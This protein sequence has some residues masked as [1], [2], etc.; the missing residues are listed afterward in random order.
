MKNY[1][2]DCAIRKGLINPIDSTTISLTGTSYQ[3]EKFVKHT[4]PLQYGGVVSV[5]FWQDYPL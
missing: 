3:L 4:A 1:C 2:H 5:F